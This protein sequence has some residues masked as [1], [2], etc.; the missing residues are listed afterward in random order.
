MQ[1]RAPEWENKASK[2]LAIKICGCC[3]SGKTVSL[4]GESIGGAHG[5]LEHIQA[6]PPG[7]QHQGYTGKVIIHLWKVWKVAKSKERAQKATL[8]SLRPLPHIQCQNAAKW[9]APPW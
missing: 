9:V 8:F 1:P 6:N 7:N 5:V 3:I 2:P 4:R